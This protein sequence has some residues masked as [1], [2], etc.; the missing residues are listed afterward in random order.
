MSD[1]ALAASDSSHHHHRR[2]RSMGSGVVLPVWALSTVGGVLLLVISGFTTWA[3]NI[4]R[5]TSG[6]ESQTRSIETA[7]DY[8]KE[9]QAHMRQSLLR[10][11]DKLDRA[12]E[13]LSDRQP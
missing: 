5:R 8:L 9:S 4:E 11:E 12:L 6:T 7:Q 10:I 13:R 3:Y 1:S 2:E